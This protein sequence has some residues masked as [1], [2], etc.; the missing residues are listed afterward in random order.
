MTQ[1]SIGVFN[2]SLF[3][4]LSTHS[5]LSWQ[6]LRL[7]NSLAHSGEEWAHIFSKHNSGKNPV[8]VSQDKEDVWQVLNQNKVGKKRVLQYHSHIAS[9]RGRVQVDTG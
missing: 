6:R 5:L 1:T 2:V 3:T 4:Q 8:D 9:S 7:A